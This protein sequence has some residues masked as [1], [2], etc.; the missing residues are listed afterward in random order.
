MVRHFLDFCKDIHCPVSMD[1]TEM[2]TSLI[3]FLGVLL[4]GKTFTLSIPIDKKLKAKNLLLWA[5][6]KRKV[7][8]HFIQKLTGSLNFF[9][10]AIVPGRTFTR[11]MYSKLKLR[12]AAGQIL[13]QHHHMN[14]SK[15]FIADCKMWMEFL[16]DDE[17]IALCQPFVDVNGF[18]D[19]NQLNFYSDSSANK[20]LLMGAIFNDRW[21][22]APWG[23]SFI[24]NCNPSIE[25]LEL[26]ALVAGIITWNWDECLRNT[27]VIVYYDNKSVRDMINGSGMI[28]GGC[29]AAS[30]CPHC[31]KLIRLLVLDNIRCNRRVFVVYVKS[32]LNVFADA[33]S[34]LDLKCFW[35]NA[36]QTVQ[37]QPDKIAETMW[38]PM[39]I[40]SCDY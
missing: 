32:Q 11:A 2:A 5:I 23:R 33:L 18:S 7:T 24:E 38:P 30:N 27:R 35:E 10:W 6:Q 31:M 17:R 28:G 21:I 22:Y 13:K 20:L 26:Y 39:K 25:F 36:P 29:E 4:N 37:S 1:K 3:S 40:W 34:R 9:N 14:L 12:N 16:Q 19:A 15:D 8:V